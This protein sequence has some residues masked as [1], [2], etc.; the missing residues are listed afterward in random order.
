MNY[1]DGKKTYLS[2]LILISGVLGL[3]TFILPEEIAIL[4]DSV[5]KIA[6]TLGVVYG[7]YMAL[8]PSNTK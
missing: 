6:G 2:L 7:R 1:L 8:K 3:S 5:L 4:T